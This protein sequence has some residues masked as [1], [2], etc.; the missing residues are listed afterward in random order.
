[1]NFFF[2]HANPYLSNRSKGNLFIIRELLLKFYVLQ[3]YCIFLFDHTQL[4]HEIRF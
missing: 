1:M 3:Y 4:S 2:L